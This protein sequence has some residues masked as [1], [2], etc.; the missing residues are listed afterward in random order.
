[1]S[2]IRALARIAAAAVALVCLAGLAAFAC[3]KSSPPPPLSALPS[4]HGLALTG[5]HGGPTR[6]GWNDD[7]PSLTPASARNLSL[8]WASSP[9]AT[10]TVGGTVFAPHLYAS[11]LYVDDIV[12]AS[13][14]FVGV[15]TSV[16]IVATSNGDVYAV[17]AVASSGDAGAV[18]PGTIL[19]SRHLGD[20]S[21]PERNL[22]GVPFGI[23][24]TPVIDARPPA[25][26]YAAAADAA[27]G[28]RVFALD[29][30]SGVVLPGWP[31]QLAAATVEAVN[32]NA[33]DAGLVTFTAF[34]ALS[35][36]GALNLSND[37]ATLYVP[38]GSYFDGATGWMVAVDTSRPGV[39]ASFSGASIDAPAPVNDAGTDAGQANLAN[40][41]M[42]GGGGGAVAPDGHLFVTTGNS[43]HD[44][45]GAPGVWGNSLLRWAPPLVLDGTY[46]PFNYCLLDR[47]DTDLAGGSPIL[48]D[49]DAARTSTPHLV[50][51]GGKQGN[52]YLVNRDQLAGRLD[53]RP[54]C[55]SGAP[56]SPSS[57]TSLYAPDAQAFY[58]PPSP[59]PLNVFGPYSDAPTANEKDNAKARTTPAYFRD[60]SGE[61]YLYYSGNSRSP[62][63]I[64]EVVA[65][66]VARLHV[67]LPGAAVPAYLSIVAANPDV[68][69][70]N[71]GSPVVSSYQS[72][73]PVVWIVDENARRS[74]P[75]VPMNGIAPALPVLYAF[76]GV[77]LDLLSRTPLPAPG[78]KYGH[79]TV[80]HGLVLVG[81]DRLYAF[82]GP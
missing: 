76:D 11:P 75:L 65:P 61:V 4:P 19:W 14:G 53:Q 70:L 68:A 7:E 59:G 48:F 2:A 15:H 17:D 52:A 24:S 3:S 77:T 42:W 44:S 34:D 37:G 35:Q 79:P 43:P 12:I 26:L 73:G 62:A 36:R 66:S 69:L 22:D 57:D 27:S 78:G 20:P 10:A 23:L 40:G 71:P 60:A 13:A 8:A 55:D 72:T 74:D 28:W 29:L 31:V 58:A 51:F 80:A 50:A 49:V 82:R 45:A 46:S 6:L 56:P 38:F 30:S 54:A 16:A 47:G 81:A 25:R 5:F 32:A 9:F 18:A 67:V 33:T 63:S 21:Q 41:G 39:V 1:M 64:A